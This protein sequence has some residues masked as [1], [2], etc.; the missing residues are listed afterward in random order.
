MISHVVMLALKPDH[1]PAECDA[2]M[3]DLASLMECLDGFRG[4]SHG[5]NR[6]FEQK[7]Q[8]YPYGFICEFSDRSALERYANDPRHQA[9]GAKLVKQCTGGADGIMVL[10]IEHT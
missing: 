2:V 7:S 6:D 8:Q 5:P 3:R 4:L 10:D 1:D 9:L